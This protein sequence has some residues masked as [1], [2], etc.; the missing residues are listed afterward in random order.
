MRPRLRLAWWWAPIFLFVGLVAGG[1]LAPDAH[2]TPVDDVTFLQV[3]DERGI[4]YPSASKVIEA[5]HLVCQFLD[6]G[7]SLPAVIKAVHDNTQLG[8][9]SAYFVGVAVGSFC[10]EHARSV[11]A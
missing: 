11:L 8:S 9:D 2:A 6:A 1:L 10:P 7:N 5:G 4:T 3:L